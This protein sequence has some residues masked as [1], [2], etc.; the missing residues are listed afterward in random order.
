MNWEKRQK[1]SIRKFS[2]GVASVVIGQFYLGTMLNAPKV[3]ADERDAAT[4]V[5]SVAPSERESLK[6]IS[7]S[8]TP[9]TSEAN[10]A[11]EAEVKQ[12]SATTSE[13][14]VSEKANEATLAPSV[15]ENAAVANT[16]VENAAKEATI[17]TETPTPNVSAE[18]AP[19]SAPVADKQASTESTVE[20]SSSRSPHFAKTYVIYKNLLYFYL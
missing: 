8:E 19:F 11:T 4:E 1:F 10:A 18:P 17:Q 16:A 13:Q 6:V 5:V 12:D 15:N 20:K 14:A 3:K 2:V 9:L 7:V